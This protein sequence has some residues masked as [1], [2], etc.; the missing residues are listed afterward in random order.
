[1][2]LKEKLLDK[3]FIKEKS[4]KKQ[5][6][7]KAPTA[8]KSMLNSKNNAGTAPKVINRYE[9][10]LDDEAYFK[11]L[12][13]ENGNYYQNNSPKLKPYRNRSYSNEQP[14]Y[15]NIPS[16]NEQQY[17]N[18]PYVNDPKFMYNDEIHNG[19]PTYG[20][21]KP[22][23]DYETDTYLEDNYSPTLY[24]TPEWNDNEFNRKNPAYHSLKTQT[25]PRE[26]TNEVRS[27]KYRLVLTLIVGLAG[28]ITT[29][30]PI[31][32][33]FLKLYLA[34][35]IIDENNR[36]PDPFLMTPL[37]I[38][39]L[40]LF[41][42]AFFDLIKI[43]REVERYLKNARLGNNVIPNF[44]IV[45]YKKMH[46][47]S[48]IIN[49]IAFPSY[50]IGAIMISILYGLSGAKSPQIFGFIILNVKIRDL[51]IEIWILTGMV[52]AVFFL[53]V[54]NI[55]FVKKRKANIIG[56]YG[57][58]IINPQEMQEIKKRANRICLFTWLV[59]LGII[60]FI[61]A[62]PLWIMRRKRNRSN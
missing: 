13:K 46:V 4:N 29:A 51:K 21:Q 9:I 56:F 16:S 25:I 50:I 34:D 49:W 57:Y 20:L 55:V 61:I 31:I 10:T 53:Q 12:P 58:E 14:T 60:F 28:I 32:L 2:S 48:I 3:F 47:R 40:G 26:I 6:D 17:R 43:K 36:I 54:L 37:C 52:F 23:L 41:F 59:I 15:H 22:L 7:S 5:L 1:M 44:I 39:S 30:I 8:S 35:R 62:L 19:A 11:E 18:P 38:F 45:N 33:W 24:Q 27:E 42:H